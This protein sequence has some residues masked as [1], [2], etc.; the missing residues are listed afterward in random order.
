[1]ARKPKAPVAPPTEAELIARAHADFYNFS[2]ISASAIAV[3]DRTFSVGDKVQ[4]GNLD[5]CVVHEVLEGGKALLIKHRPLN[6]P[7]SATSDPVPLP[8]FNFGIWWWYEAFR[9]END[10]TAPAFTRPEWRGSVTTCSF[11]S[12]AHMYGNDGLVC[13]PEYQRG[14]VWTQS[15]REALLESIFNRTTIGGFI[16][17]RNHGYLHKDDDTPVKYITLQGDT[18]FVPKKNNYAIE[19]ID[20]QQRLTTL[21]Q[22]ITNQ[23]AYKGRKFSQL[24]WKDQHAI[25]NMMCSYRM[26]EEENV[27]RKEM[28]ELFL[29]V[30]RGVPQD[31]S[32]LAKVQALYD[33]LNK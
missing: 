29:Q 19:I 23:W 33:D 25:M 31:A 1:M 21:I 24:N 28:L 26:I 8:E 32:H 5:E 20:G 12:V 6:K 7:R 14:Y 30:N 27:N 4:V 10:A 15:D 18:I 16:F 2:A 13:N 11:D 17:V 22:Y 3:P 9:G